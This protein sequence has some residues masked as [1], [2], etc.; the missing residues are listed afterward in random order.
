LK[1]I[2]HLKDSSKYITGVY[3]KN[4]VKIE[5]ARY[6]KL[7][8]EKIFGEEGAEGRPERLNCRLKHVAKP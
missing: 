5:F 1:Q 2:L 7:L 3:F 8:S 4:K 6:K